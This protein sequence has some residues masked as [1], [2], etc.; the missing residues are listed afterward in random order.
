[1]LPSA[2]LYFLTW[3]SYDTKFWREKILA[4]LVNCKRFA[5]IFLTKIFLPISNFWCVY[6][7]S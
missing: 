4:N 6:V 2:K 1:M 7:A 5:K 3:I